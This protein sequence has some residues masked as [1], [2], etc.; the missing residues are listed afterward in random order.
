VPFGVRIGADAGLV[1]QTAS[2]DLLSTKVAVTDAIPMLFQQASS[3]IVAALSADGKLHSMD[4]PAGS[5]DILVLYASGLGEYDSPVEDGTIASPPW[6][7]PKQ[8][9]QVWVGGQE[10][11]QAEILYIGAAPGLVYGAYQINIRLPE[12]RNPDFLYQIR[13]SVNGRMCETA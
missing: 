1:V 11:R 8:S 10:L 7:T 9:I 5:G 2:G 6:K 4:N 3:K 13:L 12:D